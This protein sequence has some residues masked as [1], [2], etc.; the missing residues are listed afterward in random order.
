MVYRGHVKNGVVVL[1]DPVTLPEGLQVQIEIPARQPDQF[2]GDEA[3]HTLGQMLLKYA[4]KAIG[5]P[6][7]AA[8]NHDHYLYGTPKE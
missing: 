6:S 5:L 2:A 1:D 4:G 3:S 7:D 8:R